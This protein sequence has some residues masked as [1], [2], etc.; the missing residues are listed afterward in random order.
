MSEEVYLELL[1]EAGILASKLAEFPLD[2][3]CRLSKYSGELLQDVTKYRRLVGKLLFLALTRPDITISWVSLW[4]NP[5][6][7][8][9]KMHW[10]Y[11]NISN[12]TLGKGL[13]FGANSQ[14][15]LKAHTNSDW[16]SCPN[17]RKYDVGYCVFL[18]DSLISWRTNI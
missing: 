6:C 14:L 3:N 8:I 1:E 16:A 10:K 5:E 17:I 2:Q 12:G 9:F 11:C 7:L 18:G 4:I 15:H 13:F